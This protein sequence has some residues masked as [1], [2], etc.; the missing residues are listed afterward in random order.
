[1]EKDAKKEKRIKLLIILTGIASAL[2]R[3]YYIYYTPT[4]RRQ[5]DVIA[6]GADEGQAAFIEY[7]HQGHLLLDF[8][9]REKWG[10]FQPPLHHMLSAVWIHAQ[11]LLGIA[12]DNACEHV[13]VL[14]LI[15]SLITLFFAYLIFKYV[16]LR[17]EA[18]L[19]SFAI[20]A[21]HPAFILMSGSVNNDMLA[22]LFTV[23]TVY[24]GLRW[25]DDPSWMNTVFMALAL[26]LGMMTKISSGFIAPAIAL[27]FVVRFIRGGMEN[28]AKNMTK[29]VVFCFICAPLALWSPI[30]NY[31]K[32]GVPLSYTPEVGEVIDASIFSRIFDIRCSIPYI[33][34]ISNGDAYDEYNMF[35]GM[36]K[37]SF[38]GDENFAHAISEAGHSGAGALYM[39]LFGWALFLSG[40]LLA[41]L[42]L[43]CFVRMIASRKFIPALSTR[44]YLAVLYAF[45]LLMYV[46]FMIKAPYS[47]SMDFRYVL[48]LLPVQ[49][50]GAGLYAGD[51]NCRV[52]ERRI[53][54]ALT[55][56]FILSTC[57]V[58]LM[59][60]R[61]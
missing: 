13:Q 5:H 61:A 47:S 32:F 1:M 42:C 49:A 6:F 19:I 2:L 53:I 21:V 41:V 23:I 14:T 37:T 44:A 7:F 50:M 60:G 58:Y 55:G 20:S 31:I 45:S 56:V 46:S 43:Y 22:I 10:F 54:F 15:Y 52:S 26:G 25:N 8:D 29:I 51:E 30:R 38:F 18:L 39:T 11:E 16:G 12:Y 17:G 4:W 57:A 59:L 33:S 35:L 34:R 24:L 40:T 3:L 28:F 48:Y 27:L 9:P 36:M